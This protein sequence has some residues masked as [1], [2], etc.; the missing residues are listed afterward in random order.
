M[1]KL[2]KYDPNVPN[3]FEVAPLLFVKKES[4]LILNVKIDK[5]IATDNRKKSEPLNQI[6]NFTNFSLK[7]SGIKL[8]FI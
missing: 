2:A 4:S 1:R 3:I 6:I 7:T 5:N 8:L